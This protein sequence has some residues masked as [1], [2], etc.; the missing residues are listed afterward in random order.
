MILRLFCFGFLS[1]EHGGT[2]PPH[3]GQTHAPCPGGQSANT[4]MPGRPAHP[5]WERF[6]PNVSEAHRLPLGLVYLGS[7]A[8]SFPVYCAYY[9]CCVSFCVWRVFSALKFYFGRYE[10]L[11]LLVLFVLEITLL[12]H[13]LK[14][15]QSSFLVLFTHLLPGQYSLASLYNNLWLVP[16]FLSLMLPLFHHILYFTRAYNMCIFF[17]HFL[18]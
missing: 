14:C 3:R 9:I 15:S 4:G 13:F 5:T 8:L 11:F 17:F 6:L 18:F 16:F 7:T 10:D 1:V 2:Q 12:L